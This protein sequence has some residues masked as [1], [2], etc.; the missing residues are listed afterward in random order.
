MSSVLLGCVS[1]W[2]L[3]IRWWRCG[4]AGVRSCWWFGVALGDVGMC[5]V[6]VGGDGCG[7]VGRAVFGGEKEIVTGVTVLVGPVDVFRALLPEA[8]GIRQH[9]HRSD[10]ELHL[11]YSVVPRDLNRSDVQRDLHCS[12]VQ[13]HLRFSD[14]QQHLRRSDCR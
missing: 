13:Q 8:S 14:A 9:L 4:A 5:T 11:H 12:V 2:P 3:E 1:W 7:A 6:G 10:V